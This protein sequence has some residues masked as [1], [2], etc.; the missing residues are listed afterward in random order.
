MCGPSHE[1]KQ[2]AASESDFATTLKGNYAKNFAAQ[3]DILQSLTRMFTPIAQAGPDQQG[4]GPQE[5]AALN[6]QAGEG[7][8]RNYGKAAQSLN[9]VLDSRGGGN[10]ILPTGADA[11]LR[12]SLASSAA[13]ELSQEELG[14]TRANYAQGRSNWSQATAGLN[15]LAGEYN[16]N[17]IAGE[18]TGANQSAFSEAT[19]IQEMQNQKEQAIA[20]GITSLAMG[21]ATFGMGAASGGFSGGLSAL[22]GVPHSKTG[23]TSDPNAGAME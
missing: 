19:K 9:T 15:A 2:L 8:G 17:A 4:F 13:S 14:I 11:A 22:T 5:L 7:V 10:E 3:S 23:M 20:G 12:G 1:Q 21:A 6:T 18:A 16:P